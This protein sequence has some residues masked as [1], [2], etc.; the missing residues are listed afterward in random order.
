M[1]QI[2]FYFL[3]I[4]SF[5]NRDIFGMK[6]KEED[7]DEKELNENYYLGNNDGLLIVNNDN[8]PFKFKLYPQNNHKEIKEGDYLKTNFYYKGNSLIVNKNNEIICELVGREFNF[9]TVKKGEKGIGTI[10][11]ELFKKTNSNNLKLVFVQDNKKVKFNEGIKVTFSLLPYNYSQQNIKFIK[12]KAEGERTLTNTEGKPLLASI[13]NN[14]IT[15]FY[16]KEGEGCFNAK[17]T[18]FEDERYEVKL[19]KKD[20]SSIKTKL[21]DCCCCFSWCF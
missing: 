7:E 3:F 18:I 8:T 10:E 2:G 6:A 12:L 14:K 17:E 16:K 21:K 5:V 19:V 9:T 4:L 15:I 1:R 20:D 13:E 11:C